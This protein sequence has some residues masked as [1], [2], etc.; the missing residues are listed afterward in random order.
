[1][2][3]LGLDT[4]LGRCSVA[5]VCGDAVLAHA[6]AEMERG[7]AEAL[8]PMAQSVLVQAGLRPA[9]LQRIAVTIGPGTF[10]GQR[11]GLAFARGLAAGLGVPCVGVTTTEAMIRRCA[12]TFPDADLCVAVL[13]ARRDEVYLQAGDT[14]VTLTAAPEAAALVRSL[15]ARRIVLCG[16]GAAAMARTL[17]PARVAD[18]MAPDA[19][20]VARLGAGI[21]DPASA[22]PDPLYLRA[23]DA[24]LPAPRARAQM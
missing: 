23:P 16:S 1:M 20:D 17:G 8:A 18:I 10:T 19:G 7:H 24:K 4:A 3:T 9:D 21:A 15:G 5:V 11:V 14:A 13:D 6:A 2:R 22:P 12:A